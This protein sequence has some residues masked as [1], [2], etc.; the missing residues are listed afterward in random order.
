VWCF[1]TDPTYGPKALKKAYHIGEAIAKMHDADIVHGDLTT[2]N[3]ML[4]SDDATDVVSVG[5]VL[6]IEALLADWCLQT[7]ID[8]GL[9]NSQPLPEDKAVDLYVMERAFA[10]THVKSELL[11]RTGSSNCKI[12]GYLTVW[13]W[14]VG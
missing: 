8:F 3:M 11:V 14:C 9:A 6:Q 13:R 5:A 2:S 7:M 10:S 12:T 1:V 4:S